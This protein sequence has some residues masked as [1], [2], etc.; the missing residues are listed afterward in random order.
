MDAM[1]FVAG[2]RL[3][4]DWIT[5]VSIVDVVSRRKKRLLGSRTLASGGVVIDYEIEAVS[6]SLCSYC[7][8]VTVTLR[9][10]LEQL[11]DDDVASSMTHSMASS[12][13]LSDAIVSSMDVTESTVEMNTDTPTQAPT[14]APDTMVDYIFIFSAVSLLVG[15]IGGAATHRYMSAFKLRHDTRVLRSPGP[16]GQS[17]DNDE[18]DKDTDQE[19]TECDHVGLVHIDGSGHEWGDSTWS[20]KDPEAVDPERDT[21]SSRDPE[22]VDPERDN[23]D[24]AVSES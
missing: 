6:E 1:L 20:S 13:E 2:L 15:C 4:R 11:A 19:H 14:L 22:S 17:E 23:I 9:T 16:P 21:W 3:H 24:K 12:L 8:D 5:I 7:T 10:M 18:V